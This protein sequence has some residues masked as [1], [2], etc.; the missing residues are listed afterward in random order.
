MA[1]STSVGSALDYYSVLGVSPKGSLEEIERAYRKLARQVHPDRNAGDAARAEA[2]MKQLNQI[3]ET[4]SDPLLRAAYDDQLRRE[5]HAFRPPP[6]EPARQARGPDPAPG[7]ARSGYQ[8]H[9][10]VV[11]FLRTEAERRA[12]EVPRPRRG[13]A[14]ALLVIAGVIAVAVALLWPRPE[15]AVEPPVQ[16]SSPPPSP[17]PRPA[18]MVVR[19][20]TTATRRAIR[21][22]ARVVP[23]D[24]TMDEVIASFG[25]PDRVESHPAPGDV[26][27]VYGQVRVE[28]RDGKVVGGSP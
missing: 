14:V 8:P 22:T 25:P 12:A 17:K 2:R 11:P 15:P 26:T 6:P 20:D 24:S 19:G 9:P 18:V 23:L 27:L 21:K 7:A 10:H 28:L 1:R 16:L 4:L 5:G 13:P 3:R